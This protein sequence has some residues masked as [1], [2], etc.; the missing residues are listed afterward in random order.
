MENRIV[1]KACVYLIGFLSGGLTGSQFKER[2][3]KRKQPKS[4][5]STH[6]CGHSTH[7]AMFGAGAAT[8]S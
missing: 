5:Q 7:L 4:E 6:W 2:P 8:V 1:A 3:P